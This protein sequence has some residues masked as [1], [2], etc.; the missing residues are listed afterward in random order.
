[1]RDYVF[2]LLANGMPE[3]VEERME[4]MYTLGEFYRATNQDSKALTCFGQCANAYPH[5]IAAALAIED[6]Q[7]RQQREAVAS[8]AGSPPQ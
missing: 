4:I 6:I 1:M 3:P 2:T 7:R 8:A 5:D